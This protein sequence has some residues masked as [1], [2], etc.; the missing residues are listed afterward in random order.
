MLAEFLAAQPCWR[1]VS[2]CPARQTV[3]VA[4]RPVRPSLTDLRLRGD[5]W[6]VAQ[7]NDTVGVFLDGRQLQSFAALELDVPT[8]NNQLFTLRHRLPRKVQ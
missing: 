5:P 8:L 6:I 2:R 3:T 1:I 4:V 7:P